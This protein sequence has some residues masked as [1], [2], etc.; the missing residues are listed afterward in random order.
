M[1]KGGFYISDNKSLLPARTGTIYLEL[2]LS[3]NRGREA[4]PSSPLRSAQDGP[5]GLFPAGADPSIS[6]PSIPLRTEQDRLS[7]S[8]VL[9]FWHSSLSFYSSGFYRVLNLRAKIISEYNQHKRS[10]YFRSVYVD[11]GR[12]EKSFLELLHLNLN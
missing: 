1:V 5:P 6:L 8:S 2:T 4:A 7:C 11:I 10:G 3:K 9:E 12:R